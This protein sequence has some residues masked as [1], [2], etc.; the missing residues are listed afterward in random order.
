MDTTDP[1]EAALTSTKPYLVRA[2]YDWI[3][4]NGLTPHL[5][6]ILHRL[7]FQGALHTGFEDGKTPE[8]VQF[9]VRWEGLDGSAI[10]AIAKSPLD[11]TKPQTFLSLATKLSMV[12][13]IPILALAALVYLWRTADLSPAPLPAPSRAQ[14]DR[15]R[16]PGRGPGPD[17]TVE[18]MVQS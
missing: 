16:P 6:G 13:F 15:Q 12:T 5:P 14:T 4:D 8:G 11:A 3:L 10:D 2:L 7:G 17:D 18:G 1:T 9:K